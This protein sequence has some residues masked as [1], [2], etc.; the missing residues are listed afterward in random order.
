MLSEKSLPQNCD[1]ID[2]ML[3]PSSEQL[4]LCMK[5]GSEIPNSASLCSTCHHKYMPSLDHKT[6]YNVPN[7]HPENIP[8]IKL[9]VIIGFSTNSYS[10]T[11]K[12]LCNLI[13]QTGLYQSTFADLHFS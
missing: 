10:S 3:A 9:G 8:S 4:Y 11:K 1:S 6:I 12:L 7:G 13:L 5:C 2:L